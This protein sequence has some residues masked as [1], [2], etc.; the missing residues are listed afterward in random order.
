MGKRMEELK[1]KIDQTKTY[2]IEEAIA[3]VK[4][5]STVKFDASVEVHVRLGIDPQKGDQQIRSTVSLPHGTG[6]TKRIAAFV[7]PNDE[8]AAKAAGADFVF[9]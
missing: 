2:S 9:G 4:Q 8:K 5:T 6:K 7:G 3:L 1:K